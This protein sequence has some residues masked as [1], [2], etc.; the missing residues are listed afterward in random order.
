MIT[1]SLGSRNE[2]RIEEMPKNIEDSRNP[3]AG[4]RF[5]ALTVHTR[6]SY[7]E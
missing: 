7:R 6:R 3:I 5:S 1:N 4:V 2:Q